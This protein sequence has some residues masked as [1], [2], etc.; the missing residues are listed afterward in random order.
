MLALT[1][2]ASAANVYYKPDIFILEVQFGIYL[3]ATNL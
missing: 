3:K 1:A 2:Y